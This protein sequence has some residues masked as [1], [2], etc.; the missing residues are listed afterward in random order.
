MP[1]NCENW[2]GLVSSHLHYARQSMKFTGYST[3]NN[4][5]KRNIVIKYVMCYLNI[6]LII[7][8]ESFAWGD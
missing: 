4:I 6:Q 5:N 8:S 7:L 3:H 1:E 2:L